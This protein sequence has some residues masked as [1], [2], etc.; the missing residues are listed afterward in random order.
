MKLKGHIKNRK[1]GDEK[2]P[3]LDNEGKSLFRYLNRTG[4]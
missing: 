2:K 1:V 4:G 3:G